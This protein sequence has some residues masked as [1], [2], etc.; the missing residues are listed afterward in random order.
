MC[1]RSSDS[2]AQYYPVI[3]EEYLREL[4]LQEPLSRIT[5]PMFSNREYVH[6]IDTS[7]G[8]STHH[9]SCHSDYFAWLMYS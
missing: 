5:V 3:I 6:P 1:N 7:E 8:R 4:N 2:N 9:S